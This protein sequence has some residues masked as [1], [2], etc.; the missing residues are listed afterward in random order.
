[1]SV[2]ST[3]TPRSLSVGARSRHRREIH[4]PPEYNAGQDDEKHHSQTL[5]HA[6]HASLTL[7]ASISLPPGVVICTNRA[8]W[9]SV[10]QNDT[11]HPEFNELTKLIMP[12]FH[13]ASE[14]CEGGWLL[15]SVSWCSLFYATA[16]I[17]CVEWFRY[18][19]RSRGRMLDVSNDLTHTLGAQYLHFVIQ[20]TR[21]T[22][23]SPKQ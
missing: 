13:E 23:I 3:F 17:V 11:R 15:K 20:Y 22:V 18:S 6:R 21:G 7:H 4:P 16:V 19:Q 8:I 9:R 12:M 1:M 10:K 14:G 2:L 5:R